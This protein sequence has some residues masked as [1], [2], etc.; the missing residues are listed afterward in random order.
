MTTPRS[1]FWRIAVEVRKEHADMFCSALEPFCEAVSQFRSAGTL[2]RIEGLTDKQPNPAE[3]DVAM[4]LSAAAMGVVAPT[5]RIDA[6]ED[7]DWL[8]AAADSFTPLRIGRFLIS[9]TDQRLENGHGSLHLRIDASTAFGSGRHGSTAGCLIALSQLRGQRFRRALDLG[10][11]SGILA[12]A[13]ARLWPMPVLAADVDPRA[14]Q[15]TRRHAR[16]NGVADR[17]TAVISDGL[18]TRIVNREAPF[19]LVLANIEA[20]PLQ[21]LAADMSARLVRC[22]LVV[23]AGFVTKETRAVLARFLTAGFHLVRAIT[24]DGWSTL[25]LRRG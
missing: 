21:R 16:I 5:L 13:A 3:V 1:T 24:V 20:A 19:D 9:P 17:L 14:V 10:C 6:V 2:A 23:L 25:V 18:R 4:A 22:G 11:G 12:I 7:R 15:L 8:A